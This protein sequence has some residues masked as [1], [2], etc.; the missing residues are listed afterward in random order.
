MIGFPLPESKVKFLDDKKL[1]K[2]K[3]ELS[4]VIETV[5]AVLFPFLSTIKTIVEKL[6]GL[7]ETKETLIGM[8]IVLKFIFFPFGNEI[9]RGNCFSLIAILV[10]IS[11][12]M[13]PIVF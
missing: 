2:V 10:S 5:N 13:H 4:V 3:I 11:V 8:L 7:D 6:I 1:Y 12:G 9:S